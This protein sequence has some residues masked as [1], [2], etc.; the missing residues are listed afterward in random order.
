VREVRVRGLARF[1]RFVV[2]V[3][4]LL[5]VGALALIYVRLLVA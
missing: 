4:A 1:G 5:L 2:F 3:L